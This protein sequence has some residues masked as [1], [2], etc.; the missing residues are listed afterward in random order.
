MLRIGCRSLLGVGFDD[1]F[2]HFLSNTAQ[3]VCI[4]VSKSDILPSRDSEIPFTTPFNCPTIHLLFSTKRFSRSST[5][6]IIT[7]ATALVV[8]LATSSAQET[9]I[10]FATSSLFHIFPSGSA[11]CVLSRLSGSRP[12]ASPQSRATA[13]FFISS[14]SHVRATLRVKTL[15]IVI[16][17]V[18][19]S[20][21]NLI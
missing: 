20:N 2:S 8:L 21:C 13:V 9:S 1:V 18:S 14:P 5:S 17:A 10:S 6:L 19:K 16:P 3:R 11:T 15:S 7:D 4:L 12:P